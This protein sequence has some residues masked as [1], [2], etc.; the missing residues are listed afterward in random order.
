MKQQSPNEQEIICKNVD[1][2]LC[3]TILS[4]SKRLFVD[5]NIVMT[6]VQWLSFVS[7]VSGMV[8]R[9]TFKESIPPI[10]KEI[11][12]EVSEESIALASEICRQINHLQD[13][14]KYLLSI[15]IETAKFN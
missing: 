12:S 11:F 9:S 7:H 2:D 13:D 3:R 4:Y 6:D 10:D 15:H 1:P 5:N 14:E 8:S